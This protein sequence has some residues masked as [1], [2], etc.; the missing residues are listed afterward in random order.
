M[1]PLSLHS[2]IQLQLKPAG[3]EHQRDSIIL[4]L[5]KTHT[6]GTHTAGYVRVKMGLGVDTVLLSA[7]RIQ[8]TLHVAN[9]TNLH[10]LIAYS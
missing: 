4:E 10:V 1:A 5:I 7:P 9:S 2:A 8:T 3:L 6:P